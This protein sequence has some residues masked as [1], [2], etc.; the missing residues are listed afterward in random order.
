MIREASARAVYTN[1]SNEV[2]PL[3]APRRRRRGGQRGRLQRREGRRRGAR[4]S[5]GGVHA[6]G[7]RVNDHG[8]AKV[9]RDGRLEVRVGK[10]RGG[11]RSQRRDVIALGDQSFQS[12]GPNTHKLLERYWS[13]VPVTHHSKIFVHIPIIAKD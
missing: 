5:G 11:A 1:R 10:E 13:L 9:R 12:I 6:N 7:A 2:R 8:R 3:P 4:R